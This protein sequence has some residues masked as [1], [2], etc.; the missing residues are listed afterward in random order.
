[1]P[2]TKLY[3]NCGACDVFIE[4]IKGGK[5]KQDKA[6]GEM[7]SSFVQ[8]TESFLEMNSIMFV[9][10]AVEGQHNGFNVTEGSHCWYMFAI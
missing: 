9:D 7:V 2:Q 6:L 8:L 10:D 3:L 5:A 4:V 1:M